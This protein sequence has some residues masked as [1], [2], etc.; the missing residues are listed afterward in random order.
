M[1]GCLRRGLATNSLY[2]RGARGR[3]GREAGRGDWIRTSDSCVPNSDP[4]IVTI[5]YQRLTQAD[6]EDRVSAQAGGFAQP[7]CAR[8]AAIRATRREAGRHPWIEEGSLPRSGSHGQQGYRDLERLEIP[9]GC[10]LRSK[11]LALRGFRYRQRASQCQVEVA[12]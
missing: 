6:F 4:K 1:A 10:R 8:C 2:R 12:P 9:D 5:I 11:F 3:P 7:T